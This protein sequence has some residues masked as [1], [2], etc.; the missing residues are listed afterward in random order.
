MV[1]LLLRVNASLINLLILGGIMSFKGVE[2][3]NQKCIDQIKSNN[4]R[5]KLKKNIKKKDYKLNIL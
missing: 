1:K 5:Q 2:Q 3:F 4:E